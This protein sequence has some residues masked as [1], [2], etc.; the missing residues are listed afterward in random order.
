MINSL[1]KV[2]N[3]IDLNGMNY[4]F[5]GNRSGLYDGNSNNFAYTLGVRAG[6]KDQLNSFNPNPS[7]SPISTAPGYGTTLPNTSIYRETVKTTINV[8][9]AINNSIKS[10]FKK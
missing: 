10:I 8:A 7:R 1:G 5:S 4:L 6:L 2:Y 9:K 3:E